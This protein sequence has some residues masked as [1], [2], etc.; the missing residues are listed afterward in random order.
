MQTCAMLVLPFYPAGFLQ[1]AAEHFRELPAAAAA[2]SAAAWRQL[3]AA[4]PPHMPCSSLDGTHPD[5]MQRLLELASQA[6]PLQP[7][8]GQDEDAA[9]LMAVDGQQ[10]AASPDGGNKAQLAAVRRSL[11]FL[12]SELQDK[13]VSPLFLSK[14]GA[15]SYSEACG[16]HG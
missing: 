7:V 4:E 9:A 2:R 16:T 11:Y 10:S 1:A 15:G 8:E 3:A 6:P 13:E 14:T 5:A 12:L